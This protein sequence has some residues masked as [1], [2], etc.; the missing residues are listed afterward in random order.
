M[1]EKMTKLNYKSAKGFSLLELLLVVAVGAILIL[2]G[3]AIYRNITN[4]TQ[5][6]DAVRLL[7]V[8]KQE[9]IRVYQG[10]PTYGTDDFEAMLINMDAIP[11]SSLEGSNIVTPFVSGSD[12]VSVTGQGET[13]RVSFNNVPQDACIRLFTSFTPD[14]KEFSG[15]FMGSS[16]ITSITPAQANTNCS[17]TDSSNDMSWEFR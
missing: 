6:N 11:A 16:E 7:N 4:S 1:E 14:D 15:F 9:V 17:T 13:F 5:T 2:S 12:S 3:L 10:Q 8:I